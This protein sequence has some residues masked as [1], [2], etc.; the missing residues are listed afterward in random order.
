MK[1]GFSIFTRSAQVGSFFK[2]HYGVFLVLLFLFMLAAWGYIFFQYGH[3][4]VTAEPQVT[5]KPVV[6]KEA[7]L[8]S[9]MDALR[10]RATTSEEV[11]GKTFPNPFVKPPEEPR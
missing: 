1:K 5:V 10:A 3:L 9:V 6:V 11:L 8:V 4:I 2:M 7:Q